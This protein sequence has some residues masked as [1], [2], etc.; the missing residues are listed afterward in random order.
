MKILRLP[1]TGQSNA[2]YRESYQ[3]VIYVLIAFMIITI[4]MAFLVLYQVTH[5]PLPT[6][7]AITPDAKR[8]ELSASYEPN[9][10]PTT[11]TK[12]ARKAAVA[13]YTF[14]FVNYKQQLEL[15][16]PFYT[17]NGWNGFENSVLPLLNTI[18]QNQI[19]VNGVVLKPPV[20]SNQGDYPG[21]GYTWRIQIPFLVIYQ[22]AESSTRN[23]YTVILSI[24]R[25]PTHINPAG[26]GIDQFI[27]K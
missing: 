11:L 9:L 16:R 18:T 5:R 15:A 19:I 2:F 24:V 21:Q 12:W 17:I 4:F 20:I 7:T 27:M 8:L 6:F 25:V 1:F 3:L 14:D 13:S 23:N 10:L 26:I 22:A